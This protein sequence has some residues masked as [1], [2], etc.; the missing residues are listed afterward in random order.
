MGSDLFII[1]SVLII[2]IILLLCF[3]SF[4]YVYKGQALIILF[5]GKYQKTLN[6][7]FIFLIPVIQQYKYVD[8][9]ETCEPV[10]FIRQENKK[11]ETYLFEVFIYSQIIDPFL[12]TFEKPDFKSFVI[13]HIK[14]NYQDIVSKDIEKIDDGEINEIKSSIKQAIQSKAS[15]WGIILHRIEIWKYDDNEDFDDDESLS[16]DDDFR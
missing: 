10:D 4:R 5:L 8:L 7:G 9:L 12:A 3:F 14:E 2:T 16:D 13:T 6:S 11:D 15:A 1:V